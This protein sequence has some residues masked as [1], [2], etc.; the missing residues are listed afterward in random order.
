MKESIIRET[1]KN[2]LREAA[3]KETPKDKEKDVPEE[4]PVEDDFADINLDTEEPTTDDFAEP[5][6]EGEGGKEEVQNALTTALEASRKL[7]DEKLVD[8]I[9]NLITFFTRT[10]IVGDQTQ[11]DGLMED[12]EIS[13]LAMYDED[14]FE[15]S[16]SGWDDD[17]G[18]SSVERAKTRQSQ[19]DW[20]NAGED[21][22][23][24]NFLRENKK[25]S[26]IAGI[27]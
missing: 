27:L 16:D 25:W 18:E 13:E 12:E 5:S 2:K 20:Q 9:G 21:D 24:E 19:R 3:K 1:I 7:G 6:G 11:P 26:K 8:Q 10:H 17:G 4:A 22:G 15:N 14:E 23:D